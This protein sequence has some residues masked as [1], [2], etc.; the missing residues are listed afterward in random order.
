M[1]ETQKKLYR[2]SKI[3][4]TISKLERSKKELQQ[5]L[6]EHFGTTIGSLDEDQ[7]ACFAKIKM[8]YD[9]G[10]VSIFSKSRRIWDDKVLQEKLSEELINECSRIVYWSGLRFTKKG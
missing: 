3:S 10:K 4:A 8:E 6:A 2:L 7:A 5:E 9:Y 1:T